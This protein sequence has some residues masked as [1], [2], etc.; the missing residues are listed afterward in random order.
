[1]NGTLK[2]IA[3]DSTVTEIYPKTSAD[4]VTFSDT[5]VANYLEN[6]SVAEVDT[7]ET[8]DV[9][10][11][12]E[13][14]SDGNIISE[15]YAPKNSPNFTG[16]PTAPTSENLD[17]LTDQVATVAWCN[18]V[19]KRFTG[20]VP[21]NMDT[22][23]EF[24]AA[25]GQDSDLA[26]TIST[27]LDGKQ[28][29][30]DVLTA[31]S[32]LTF[33]ADKII[34]ATGSK[35]FSTTTLTSTAREII[36]KS[37]AKE[38]RRLLGLYENKFFDECENNWSSSGSP[39]ILNGELVMD[40]ASYGRREK[41]VTLGG[42]NPFTIEFF[43]KANVAGSSSSPIFSAY[44]DAN[45]YFAVNE[46]ST[47]PRLFWKHNN[48]TIIGVNGSENIVGE[49]RHLAVTYDGTTIKY[50]VDGTLAHS[51]TQT[52]T[53]KNYRFFLGA[54]FSTAGF[55]Y[56]NCNIDEFRLSN[57]CRYTENFTPAE[58]FSLDENTLSLLHF[59]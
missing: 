12:A 40:G 8:A 36:S 4:L 52:L 26:T 6:F 28:N 39:Q 1:M 44:S 41:L 22:L 2:Y 17:L 18:N 50:F 59:D 21:E 27:A 3:S 45:Y 53:E 11:V 42:S 33:D 32:N 56:C 55:T 19:F 35:T 14:D 29:K 54:Q 58:T 30:S 43:A 46:N 47:F 7:A 31:F 20:I 10:E 38:I 13:K 49:T 25:L 57:V 37:T 48:V 34:F 9:A 16:T 5:T 23:Q 15:T 51:L 24:W